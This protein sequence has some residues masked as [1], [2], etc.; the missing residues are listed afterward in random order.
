[1]K[2]IS[3]KG[4]MI[5]YIIVSIIILIVLYCTHQ[6]HNIIELLLESFVFGLVATGFIEILHI[7][8]D[9]ILNYNKE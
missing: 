3:F 1:M 2:K 4:E 9:Y 8:I 7:G 5:L 6:Y